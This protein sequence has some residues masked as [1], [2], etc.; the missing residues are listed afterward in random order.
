MSGDMEALQ[1]AAKKA[2]DAGRLVDVE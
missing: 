1:R 2:W